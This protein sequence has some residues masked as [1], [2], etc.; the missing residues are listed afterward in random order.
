M[1]HRQT[2][3]FNPAKLLAMIA[4]SLTLWLLLWLVFR[5]LIV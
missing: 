5:W 1:A 3:A 4:V 2:T